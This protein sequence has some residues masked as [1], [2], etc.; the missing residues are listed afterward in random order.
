VS[1]PTA[2]LTTT[3]PARIK[4]PR[5]ATFT[6]GVT[7]GR[8][9]LALTAAAL[10]LA[11]LSLLLPSTPSYDPWSWLIWGRQIIHLDLQTTGGPSW[12]PLP[13]LFTTIFAP[14]GSAQPD[15]LLVLSRAGALMAIAM[16]FRI[17]WRI[18]R[19]LVAE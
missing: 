4:S 17:A 13:V 19:P 18:A 1:T 3:A 10:T 9:Y 14:F 7:T 6:A 11:A 15:L 16:T 12:K 2:E 5:V 8:L